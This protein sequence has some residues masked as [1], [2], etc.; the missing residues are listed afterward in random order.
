MW[1]RKGTPFGMRP[2]VAHAVE[3]VV[4]MGM[5]VAVTVFFV[6]MVVFP[7]AMHAAA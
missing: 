4:A 3:T 7:N 5:T 2:T 6:G 1:F